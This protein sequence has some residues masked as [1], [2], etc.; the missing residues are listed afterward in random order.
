MDGVLEHGLRLVNEHLQLLQLLLVRFLDLLVSVHDG[1]LLLVAE[2]LDQVLNLHLDLAN[3]VIHIL[4]EAF[5]LVVLESILILNVGINDETIVRL[6]L[7][8]VAELFEKFEKLAL[9]HHR[10]HHIRLVDDLDHGDVLE[11]LAA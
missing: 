10:A 11:D 7:V 6:R 5:P 3:V 9:A 4:L 8:L 2:A 1:L